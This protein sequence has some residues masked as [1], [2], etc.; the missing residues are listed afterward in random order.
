MST[1]YY[2]ESLDANCQPNKTITY[3]HILNVPVLS[4]LYN[5]EFDTSL[6]DYTFNDTL[7]MQLPQV[8]L[9]T[10]SWNKSLFRDNRLKLELNRVSQVLRN[11]SDIYLTPMDEFSNYVDSTLVKGDSWFDWFDIPGYVSVIFNVIT[12]SAVIYLFFRVRQLSITLAILSASPIRAQNIPWD[13]VGSV[14][15]TE[16]GTVVSGGTSDILLNA[17]AVVGLGLI[18]VLCYKCSFKCF[19]FWKKCFCPV[20]VPID[21]KLLFLTNSKGCQTDFGTQA[22]SDC[23]DMREIIIEPLCEDSLLAMNTSSSVVVA[24][25][26]SDIPDTPLIRPAIVASVAASPEDD[27]PSWSL[28]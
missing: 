2:F 5:K 21:A 10:E 13:S 18:V 25:V 12:I 15:T 7:T 16:A 17:I 8:K 1:Y 6:F 22:D 26:H 9:F 28:F 3:E 20:K 27:T 11:H 19:R 24:D 23:L 14:L 4:T